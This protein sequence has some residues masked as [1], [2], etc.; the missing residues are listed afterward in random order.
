M[1][2]CVRMAESLHCP[3]ETITTLLTGYTPIQNKKLVKK[4]YDDRLNLII[5]TL[6]VN[7]INTLMT[8]QR[9]SGGRKKT[10]YML[11]TGTNFNHLSVLSSMILTSHR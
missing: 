10:R 8:K 3:P 4:L 9:L 11:S 6:H 2:T 1:D 7:S 5:I